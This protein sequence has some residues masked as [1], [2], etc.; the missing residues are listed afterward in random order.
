MDAKVYNQEGKAV[1]TVALP[2]NVFELA[3]NPDLVHQVAVSMQ[4]NARAKVAHTKDRSEVRG[5]GRKPW[6][7][8]GT[9][10]A[11]HGSNRSP[12]WRGG[13]VT[14]GP[15]NE[16]VY[17][18]KIN[19]KMRVKALHTVLSQKLKDNEIL[20]LDKLELSEPRT[21]EA[22]SILSALSTIPS[23]GQFVSKKKNA[24]LIA[25]PERGDSIARSF[26]NIGSVAVEEVRNLN[27]I[28]T[29]TYKYLVL[30]DPKKSVAVLEKRAKGRNSSSSRPS[31]ARASKEEGEAAAPTKRGTLKKA[32]AAQSV[33]PTADKKISGQKASARAKSRRPS[34]K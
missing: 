33:K 4:A 16:K 31:V 22:K 12:I 11:R 14:F 5:G 8:K 18:K 24:V 23:F 7:Q 29:L 26:R 30:A 21:R 1:S 19:K 34:K 15:R 9:G 20:L 6:K 2:S 17:T 27:P 32:K 25:I 10:R 13:G 28:N 3:W